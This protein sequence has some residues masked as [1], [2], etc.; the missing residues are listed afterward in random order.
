MVSVYNVYLHL[1][2]MVEPGKGM[3]FSSSVKH[4]LNMHLSAPSPQI[5]LY[6]LLMVTQRKGA[7]NIHRIFARFMHVCDQFMNA[8]ELYCLTFGAQPASGFGQSSTATEIPYLAR[9]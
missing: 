6:G 9:R 8:P 5:H 3:R 4:L 7:L 1:L 2:C